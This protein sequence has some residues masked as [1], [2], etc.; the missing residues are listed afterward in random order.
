[1]GTATDGPKGEPTTGNYV[2]VRYPHGRRW[3]AVAVT[4]TRSIATRLAA[5]A[6]R[7]LENPQG[8]VP[9]QVRVV[10]A[11]QLRREGGEPAIV[12]AEGDIVS[13]ADRGR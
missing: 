13:R 8:E 11:R 12:I 9:R 5:D 1:V 4:D 6:Y 7:N 2:Q 3:V 10:S